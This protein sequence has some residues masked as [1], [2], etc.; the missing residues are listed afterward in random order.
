[1]YGDISSLVTVLQ[2]KSFIH[3][4]K[5]LLAQWLNFHSF[6]KEFTLQHCEQGPLSRTYE[7]KTQHKNNAML[8]P[9]L[10]R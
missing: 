4:T 6:N 3:E 7:I 5:T 2:V 9:N 10:T 8:I 1:M